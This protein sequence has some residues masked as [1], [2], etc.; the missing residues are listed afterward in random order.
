MLKYPGTQG[1]HVD[2]YDILLL[3]ADSPTHFFFGELRTRSIVRCC[4][5]SFLEVGL[6][7]GQLVR[8]AETPVGVPSL[9]GYD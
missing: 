1:T 8:R 5:A 4:R 7:L 2:P 6:L 3:C 9:Q